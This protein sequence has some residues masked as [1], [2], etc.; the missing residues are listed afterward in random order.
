MNATVRRLENNMVTLGTGVIVLG[1]WSV[2]KVAFEFVLGGAD[3]INAEVPDELREYMTITLIF[4]WVLTDI[5]LA[6]RVY[7]GLSSRAAGKGKRKGIAYLVWTIVLMLDLF[8]T[9]CSDFYIY[10]FVMGNLAMA[11]I[12]LLIDGTSFFI[13]LELFLSAVR[14]GKLR[15]QE[16]LLTNEK[17]GAAV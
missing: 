17:G 5:E 15:K 4:F 1:I 10:A 7:I 2:L 14:L 16:S 13:T 3:A 8:L 6:A 12:T 11:I 9:A